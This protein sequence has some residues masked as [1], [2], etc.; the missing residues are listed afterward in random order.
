MAKERFVFLANNEV[1]WV[2]DIDDEQYFKG[3]QV[4][5]GLSSNPKIVVVDN[6]VVV[7]DF[8]VWDGTEFKAPE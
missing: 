1:F 3:P 2:L 6:N 5:A 4:R 8:S 7:P